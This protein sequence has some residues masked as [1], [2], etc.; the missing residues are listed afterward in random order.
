MSGHNLMYL[1]NLNDPITTFFYKKKTY[2]KA[3]AGTLR[4]KS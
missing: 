3:V 1:Q 2:K 4:D